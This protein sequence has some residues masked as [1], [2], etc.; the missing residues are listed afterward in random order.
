MSR[1]EGV[2]ITVKV[3]QEGKI[4]QKDGVLAMKK[5]EFTEKTRIVQNGCE[6]TKLHRIRAVNTFGNVKAGD[7]G[8]WIESEECLSHD[9]DAWVYGD[10]IVSGKACICDNAQVYGNAWVYGKARVCDE[11]RVYDEAQVYGEAW[12]YDEARVY[13]KAWIYGDTWIRENAQVCGKA[14]ICDEA[15]IL[16][17][18]WV[19]DDAIVSGKAC[20]CENAQVCGNAWVYGN[21][22]VFDEA[23]IYDEARVYGEARI[24]DEARV[25]GKAWIYDEVQVCGKARIYGEASVNGK[26]WI[27]DKAR[28]RST[29]NVLTVG[30]IGSRNDFAT[31]YSGEKEIL[32]KCGCFCGSISEFLEK[33]RET[34]GNGRHALVYQAVAETAC[35]QIIPQDMRET[36]P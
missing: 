22:R 19:C 23:R 25:Y 4:Q 24:C 35:R 30:P 32:V 21:A 5:Y 33:V 8:G 28:I 20:I 9:G 3:T 12:I 15:R 10:A 27:C 18:A 13:G 14:R 1:R 31:F 6:E 17:E 34:H 29:E 26:A 36:R 11:A 16:G 2:E 7:I